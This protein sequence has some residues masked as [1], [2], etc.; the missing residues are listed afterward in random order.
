MKTDCIFFEAKCSS[1]PDYRVCNRTSA[2][3]IAGKEDDE[4]CQQC[5]LWDSYIPSSAT[6]YQK[7]KAITWQDMELTVQPDYNEYFN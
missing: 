2:L 3:Y 6:E 4:M 7:E 5:R 1:L